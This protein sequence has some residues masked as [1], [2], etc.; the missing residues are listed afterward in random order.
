[1]AFFKIDNEIKNYDWG[2]R[3]SIKNMF[4]ISNPYDHPQAEIW[5]GA[6]PNGCSKIANT[7]ELL[8]NVINND[9]VGT[10]GEKVV[11][12]FND[13][14]F[15]FKVLAAEKPLSIQVHP[16]KHN[17]E[18]GFAK[19]NKIG[20][21]QNAPNRNYK[22]GNHK[23]ELLYA[24]T[25]F[26]AMNGFRPIRDI[27]TIFDELGLSTIVGIVDLLRKEQ[28]SSGLREFFY[29]I[30]SLNLKEK[31]RVLD[32][33][34]TIEPKKLKSTLTR[35]AFSYSEV[36]SEYYPGDIGILSPFI[37][38]IVDLQPGE[39]MFL[40]PETPHAYVEGTA[41][42]VM[43]NSDNVLRAG[44]TPK[45]IDLDELIENVNFEPV[46]PSD[47]KMLPQLYGNRKV[48]PI[49]VID[50]GFEVVNIEH[51]YDCELYTK[52]LEIIFCIEGDV[53]LYNNDD[54]L[55]LKTGESAFIRHDAINYSLRGSGKL[56][57][58]YSNV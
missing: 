23:P 56:G 47:L 19:E 22:D 4:N 31:N 2:S 28:N 21:A 14:P 29:L 34:K 37:L 51:G 3:T 26:R 35:D 46:E 45:Y 48:Y 11:S 55:V 36:F 24:L 17:S 33:L 41:L 25:S 5:M 40:F 54:F 15:L 12:E 44:L 13:L 27:L 18:V 1:M 9:K 53:R 50:F 49:P 42:E 32:E 39:A 57:R 16:N 6:H 10:L 20:I 43:A 8:S 30:M 7:G 58:V 52:S 38:N